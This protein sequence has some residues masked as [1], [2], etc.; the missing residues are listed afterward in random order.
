MLN[1]PNNEGNTP[2][3]CSVIHQNPSVLEH[4]LKNKLMWPDITLKNKNGETL[5]EIVERYA[6]EDIATIYKRHEVLILLKAILGFGPNT[7]ASSSVSLKK[8]FQT[9]LKL[10]QSN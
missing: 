1:Q 5:R 9:T 4:L 7:R 10:W 6:T 2:L 8:Y 3:H